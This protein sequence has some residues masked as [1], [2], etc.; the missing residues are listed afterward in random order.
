MKFTLIDSKLKL[1]KW[2]RGQITHHII[3]N[4]STR[5]RIFVNLE[6]DKS[7]QYMKSVPLILNSNSKFAKLADD[8][9][10]FNEY[11][12]IDTDLMDGIVVQA[13]LQKGKDDIRYIDDMHIDDD[14]YD[15]TD[16]EDN[17]DEV[18]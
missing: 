7:T 2:Y 12:E 3:D 17:N 8:L 15:Q 14:W 6:K 4:N 9:E 11:G 5:I 13:K 18:D 1:G 10:I 16:E